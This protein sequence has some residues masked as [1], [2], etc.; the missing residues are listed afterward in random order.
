MIFGLPLFITFASFA[1]SDGDL[2]IHWAIYIAAT[3][4]IAAGLGGLL[5]WFG[6]AKPLLREKDN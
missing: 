1:Y 5:I 4:A 3:C 2:T 6:I